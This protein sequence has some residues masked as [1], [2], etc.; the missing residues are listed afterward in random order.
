MTSHTPSVSRSERRALTRAAILDASR[1]LFRENGYQ[2]TTIRAIARQVGVDP[3][4]VIHHFGTKEALFQAASEIEFDLAETL[5]G[6]RDELS[7]R[8]LAYLLG[9]LDEEPDALLATLRSMLTHEQAAE[10][11]RC[12]FLDDGAAKISSVLDGDDAG[13]RSGLICTVL[14]GLMVTRHLLKLDDVVQAPPERLIELLDPCLRQ[15]VDAEAG[16]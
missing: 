12:A 6:P 15:L 7:T 4:L 5:P 10:A 11:A 13:L 8:V 9:K 14:V 16:G 1:E 2:G 3:A